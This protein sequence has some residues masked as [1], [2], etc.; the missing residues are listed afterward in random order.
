[1]KTEV[2]RVFGYGTPKGPCNEA[3]LDV[4][5]QRPTEIVKSRKT[6]NRT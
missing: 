6:R 5:W 2:G 4:I 1:M 3:I